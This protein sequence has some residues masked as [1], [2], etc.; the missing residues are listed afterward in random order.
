MKEKH[1]QL[2]KAPGKG[3]R[4]SAS[5][6]VPTGREPGALALDDSRMPVSS[7][8]SRTWLWGG[9]LLVVGATLWA[10]WPTLAEM[11]NQWERQPDYSHGYLVLPLAL[12]F[13]W[14]RR[15]TLPYADGRPSLAGLI[16]LLAA[17]ILRI[18]AG[19]YYLLPLDG[20]TLPLTVAGLVCLL[21]GRAFLRWSL[22]AIAFLWFMVPM[23]YSAERWLS[24]PLQFLA[25]KLSAASLVLLGQ[26][27]IAEGNT[28]HLG[29]HTLFVAEACSGM[30]IFFGIFALAFAFVLFSRWSWWQKGLVLV[31]VLPV[32]IVANVTR[33]VATGLLYQW[34]SSEAGAK[35]SH[36]I[37]GFVMIPFA[38]VLFWLLLVYLDKL[39][40]Q[41]EEMQHP[42]LRHPTGIQET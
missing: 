13:L 26:P 33:I 23:P 8:T 16:L 41:V 4:D 3:D 2:R 39:F 28:L 31:A 42:H 29:E 35:F 6:P 30:R 25:T 27:A 7:R 17:T 24:V 32:A 5:A 11:V 14:S 1:G 18:L 22:P 19:M 37:A 38:A 34:V 9:S 10:Y 21:Y 36:D 15:S 20:W 40:P 12:F